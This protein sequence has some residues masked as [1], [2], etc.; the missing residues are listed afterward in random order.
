[1]MSKVGIRVWEREGGLYRRPEYF[2]LPGRGQAPRHRLRSH[3]ARAVREIE[4]GT[5]M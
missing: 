3:Q 5:I 2:V 4:P 1:M